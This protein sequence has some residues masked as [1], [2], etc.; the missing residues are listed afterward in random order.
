M[1]NWNRTWKREIRRI[2]LKNVLLLQKINDS[3]LKII[4]LSKEN[5][6][7]R[8][9]LENFRWTES[10]KH[11]NKM[12]RRSLPSLP[13][14]ADH[15][16][17]KLTDIKQTDTSKEEKKFHIFDQIER[18][19]SKENKK[20]VRKFE[21]ALITIK[22]PTYEILRKSVLQISQK[23]EPSLLDVR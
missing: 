18:I 6:I 12:R 2:S 8:T 4:E 19:D 22:K 9:N 13:V 5:M 1:K 16:D 10:S 20:R 11:N 7:L 15:Q 21:E 23:K 3:N 14:N 17:F